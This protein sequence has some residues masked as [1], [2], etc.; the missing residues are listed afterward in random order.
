MGKQTAQAKEVYCMWEVIKQKKI[1]LWNKF[2]TNNGILVVLARVLLIVKIL[3]NRKKD[4]KSNY[5]YNNNNNN[6]N[7]DSIII[8]ITIITLFNS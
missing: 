5:N 7:N 6:N 2:S 8:I 3:K 1:A 4:I